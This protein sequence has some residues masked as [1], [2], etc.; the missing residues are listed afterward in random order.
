MQCLFEL[1]LFNVFCPLHQCIKAVSNIIKD[2][3]TCV[4]TPKNCGLI[5][6]K[7]ALAFVKPDIF[8]SDLQQ[9]ILKLLK[10]KAIQLRSASYGNSENTHCLIVKLWKF[11][12]YKILKQLYVTPTEVAAWNFLFKDFRLSVVKRK[13]QLLQKESLSQCSLNQS[14]DFL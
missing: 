14:T 4:P 13:R 8:L 7:H 1:C 3:A 2:N 10:G 9:S 5:H 12:S 11:S 6:N